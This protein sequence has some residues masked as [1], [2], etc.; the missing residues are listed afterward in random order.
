LTEGIMENLNPYITKAL[1]AG[2]DHAIVVQ[3][4][5]I[6]TAPWVRMK[7]QFGCH[8]YGQSHCC[9][10]RTPTPDE[11]RRVLD[12]YTYAILLHRNWKEGLQRIDAFNDAVVGTEL[13]LFI[14]GYY[15]AWSMGS[16][17]CRLCEKCNISGQCAHGS[18]A[19]P[20][21]EACGIDVFETARD[22]GLPI[23]VLKDRKAERHSYGLVLVE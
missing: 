16:G 23:S 12:S 13:A 19:R 4:S 21:M 9:P 8:R 14:D 17:P 7:C 10:P 18:K 6:Y 3:T 20:S 22:H 15:K 5:K 1:N 2:M 11:T